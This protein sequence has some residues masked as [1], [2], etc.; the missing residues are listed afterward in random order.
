VKDRIQS[1]ASILVSLAVIAVVGWLTAEQMGRG[2]IRA[3]RERDGGGTG[4]SAA[5]VVNATDGGSATGTGTATATASSDGGLGTIEP[6]DAGLALNAFTGFLDAGAMPTGAP[7]SVRLGVVLVQWAGAEG[8]SS[9]ARAKP[10][11]LKHATELLEQAKTDWKA[12]VKAGDVGSS[13]DIG[14]IPRGVLDR[15]T[16][17]SVFSLEKDQISEPL[18]TPRG[19]WIVKRVE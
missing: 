6:G 5:A 9:S 15:A 8:A 12:T 19:Y 1:W 7:K 11:A 3:E 18:E 14:R 13:E 4:G 16:E 17:L 10:D 2:G